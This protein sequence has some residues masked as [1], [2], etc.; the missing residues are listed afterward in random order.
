VVHSFGRFNVL[1]AK[2]VSPAPDRQQRQAG[3]PRHPATRL[4]SRAIT[5]ALI[6]T[7]K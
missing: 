3:V 1:Q 5:E 2:K 7:G 6:W 4:C